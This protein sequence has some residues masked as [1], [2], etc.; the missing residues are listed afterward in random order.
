MMDHMEKELSPQSGIPLQL[1]Q[2]SIKRISLLVT[3]DQFSFFFSFFHDVGMP[4]VFNPTGLIPEVA[5]AKP[6][7]MYTR[8]IWGGFEHKMWGETHAYA[9]Q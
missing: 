8:Q 2:K 4:E 5:L 7:Q 6:T 1:E 9:T 3:T